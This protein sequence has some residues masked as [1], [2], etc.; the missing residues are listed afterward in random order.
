MEIAKYVV[1]QEQGQWRGYLRDY[2][3]H[4]AQGESFEILELKLSRLL[5]DLANKKIS[6]AL[7]PHR[8][9]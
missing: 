6:G 9:A 4:Q 2:P 1:W 7:P 3:D 5:H 8:A